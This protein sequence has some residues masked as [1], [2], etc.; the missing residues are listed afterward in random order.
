VYGPA[1]GARLCFASMATAALPL[2]HLYGDPPVDQAFDFIHV[3]TIAAR[4]SVHD[5]TI[6]AH[7]HRDLFQVLLI[8]AGGGEMSYETAP[9]PFASPA[10]VLVPPRIAHGFRFAPQVTSGW[11]VSFSEDVAGALGDRSGEALERLMALATEPV[12]P[13]GDIQETARVSALCHNC[14]RRGSLPAR[15]TGWRCGRC[16][17]LSRSRWCASRRAERAPVR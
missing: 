5:W 3:E 13:L 4:S 15:D 6:R 12:L 8:E 9:V 17:R 7:R 10:V 16:S 2:F 14:R 11:V 1:A